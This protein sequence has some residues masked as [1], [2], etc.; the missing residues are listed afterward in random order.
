[1]RTSTSYLCTK[2]DTIHRTNILKH[3]LLQ[4]LSKTK[5]YQRFCDSKKYKNIGE[6]QDALLN[7]LSLSG[8]SFSNSNGINGFGV[9]IESMNDLKILSFSINDSNGF[10]L[11]HFWFTPIEIGSE[12]RVM[13][14]DLANIINDHIVIIPLKTFDDDQ[15]R[16]TFLGKKW[17]TRKFNGSYSLPTMSLYRLKEI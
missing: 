15:V 1:M 3:Q 16:Y 17:L 11:N 8:I 7:G 2:L 13:K 4:P 12:I 6:I 14:E 9:L 5:R 10:H